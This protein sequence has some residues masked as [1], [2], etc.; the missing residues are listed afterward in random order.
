MNFMKEFVNTH[1]K[2]W[3]NM[4][5]IEN[6]FTLVL[7]LIAVIAI[8]GAIYL[9]IKNKNFTE[10][11]GDTVVTEVTKIETGTFTKVHIDL[12]NSNIEILDSEDDSI[13]IVYYERASNI[14]SYTA[15]NGFIELIEKTRFAIFSCDGFNFKSVTAKLYLPVGWSGI[16]KAETTN[17]SLSLDGRTGLKRLAL[18]S[19]NGSI[20][21]SNTEV[22]EY[23]ETNTTNGKITLNSVTAGQYIKNETTNGG[24][25]LIRVKGA[26][27]ID[28]SS[29]NGQINC[30]TI[31][32]K[33]LE[34]K[35]TNSSINVTNAIFEKLEAETTNSGINITAKGLEEDFNIKMYTVNGSVYLDGVKKDK[36]TITTG[37][38]KNIVLETTNGSIHL[39]FS[40]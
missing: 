19:T 20:D 22:V 33:D 18:Y 23:I 21:L 40:E 28:S 25:T 17:G 38:D 3:K 12:G 26:L 7:S 36:G 13:K 1:G 5:K 24:I 2:R 39:N 14:Y 29:T 16:L 15:E 4:K 31:E 30:T 37:K 8:V 9:G 27:A 6:I 32:T 34:L 35:T 10:G 11:S